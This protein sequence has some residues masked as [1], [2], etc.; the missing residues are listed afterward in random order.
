MRTARHL[1]LLELHLLLLELLLQRG[2][3]DRE[4]VL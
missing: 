3:L 1:L 4:H 2:N